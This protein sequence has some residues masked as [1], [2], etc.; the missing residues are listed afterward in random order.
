MGVEFKTKSVAIPTG[1]GRRSIASSVTFSKPVKKASVALNGFKLDYENADH[2]AN[3]IEAD[4]DV[5]NMSGNQVN[6]RV[7][8]NLADKNS[9][10]AYSGF[11]TALVIA[12]LES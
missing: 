12:E 5:V 2:H 4:T 7:E 9:D 11:V 1:S 8:C 10:D 6:F 3:I